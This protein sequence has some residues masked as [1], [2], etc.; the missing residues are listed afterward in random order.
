MASDSK[1][2]KSAPK[3]DMRQKQLS[4][5]LLDCDWLTALTCN[6]IGWKQWTGTVGKL[7]KTLYKRWFR[8]GWLVGK[9]RKTYYVHWCVTLPFVWRHQ[10]TWWLCRAPTHPRGTSG[11]CRWHL[12]HHHSWAIF[13]RNFHGGGG[14]GAGADSATPPPSPHNFWL[15]NAFG[16]KFGPSNI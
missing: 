11:L 1:S 13:D 7:Q 4:K 5:Y 12:H 6:L 3:T 14:G 2:W 15:A 16:M 8:M 10:T 9:R